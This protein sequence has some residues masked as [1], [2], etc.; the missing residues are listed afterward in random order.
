MIQA[1][2]TRASTARDP[3]IARGIARVL[4]VLERH[5][6]ALGAEIDGLV[7]ACEPL[8]AEARR[9]RSAPGVG[10]L[11]SATLVAR[12]PELGRLDRR[13]I[14]A[15]AGLAPHAC[16]SGLS[17][18]SRH[19]SGEGLRSAARSTS[20]PS[21]RAAATR[22]SGVPPPPPGRRQAPQGRHH[23]L[24]QEAPHHPRRN[25]PAPGRTTADRPRKRQCSALA[26]S[27]RRPARRSAPRLP[28]ARRA[29]RRRS[30][31]PETIRD[32]KER[33]PAGPAEAIKSRSYQRMKSPAR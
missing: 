32:D 11:V 22:A 26:R 24:R 4:R 12:L 33:S 31:Q 16:D 1:E 13:R 30:D 14:A 20:P 17:R 18:G 28:A 19:V 3:W 29:Q 7:A 23:R 10:P 21:S 5:L 8:A 25:D 27:G 2:K 6:A 15:L 9:L